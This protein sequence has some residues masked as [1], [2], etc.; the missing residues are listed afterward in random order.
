[1]EIEILQENLATALSKVCRLITSRPPIPILTHVFLEAKSGQL[2]LIAS[3]TETT[4]TA[5]IGAKVVSEGAFTLPAKIL[6]E[7]VSSLPA[8][9]LLLKV[10][11]AQL[12]IKAKSFRGKLSGTSG[13]E[14]PKLIPLDDQKK[15]T[16]QLRREDFEGMISHTV[17][18]AATDESRAVLTG[19]LVRLSKDTVTLAATDGFRLSQVTL[20][21]V[22][23]VGLE[24]ETFI[25]PAH[26]LSEM[27][28]FLADGTEKETAQ[29][30]LDIY[31]DSQVALSF[32]DSKIYSRLIAGK[33]PNFESIIPTSFEGKFTL[34]SEAFSKTL[35]LAAIFAR[36]SA[37]I[38]KLTLTPKTSVVSL[39]ANAAQ[40]GENETTTEIVW[41]KT[42][43]EALTIAFNYRY[44]LDFVGNMGKD[45][46]LTF[47]HT[48]P[49]APGVFRVKG[50]ANYF[51]V[52]MP[53][54][55]QG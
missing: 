2:T 21:D 14:F 46:E 15:G 47:E 38:V 54:R 31:G 49:L 23:T 26:S 22:K 5:Q 32:G 3:N 19:V 4:V 39:S 28:R 12:E 29:I 53:V 43:S 40:V 51:H 45:K 16:M 36:E 8:D 33:F 52:V 17:F 48:G 24:N 34:E 9:K 55:V 13:E 7:L 50:N 10:A 18:A 20:S 27:L 37:N 1:M 25:I 42:P 44:L 35:R 6:F 41:D 11:E 30:S